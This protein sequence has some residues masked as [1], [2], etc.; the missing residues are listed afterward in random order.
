MENSFDTQK[1]LFFIPDISGFTQFINDRQIQHNDRIIA[2]LLEILIESNRL[3]LKVNEIE[4][5]A[6]FFYRLG[7]PPSAREIVEQSKDMYIAFHRHLK[8]YGVSRICNC[9]ACNTAGRLT[10][11]TVAHYGSLSFQKIQ[12]REKLFG[13]DVIKVHRLLKNDVPDKEYILLTDSITGEKPG[14]DNTENWLKWNKG[15]A[16]YDVG[17]VGYHYASLLPYYS[18]IPEPELPLVKIH[19]S[20]TPIVFRLEINSPLD[21]VYDALIDLNQRVQ[22]MTGLKVVKVKEESLNRMNKICTSFECASPHE[23]C[24]FQ[25]SAVEFGERSIR[26]SET[27]LEQ[28][29]TF[30]Y[31]VEERAGKT[32]LTLECHPAF[33][34]PV[35]WMF[36][37]FMRKKFNSDTSRS[38]LQLKNYCELKN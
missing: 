33:S 15:N 5:D 9:A 11:K 35:K 23:K 13:P 7:Q 25:T 34:L 38:L 2:E 17:E 28:P 16:N 6:I 19:R 22:W 14:I 8:K 3:N 30:D 21:I 20:K 31:I 32:N 37:L 26:L 36:N 24:T 12:N 29:M 10:L 27:F 18:M 4:G 1:A